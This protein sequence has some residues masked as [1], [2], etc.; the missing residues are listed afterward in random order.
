[1]TKLILLLL[2]T[3]LTASGQN[4]EVNRYVTEARKAVTNKDYPL[5]YEQL[6]KAHAFHPYHQGILY[7]LGV[8]AA[9][10]GKPDESIPYL[11]KA[12]YVNAG[13]KLDIPELSAVKDRADFQQLKT[14]QTELQK[15]VANADTAFVVKDRSLHAESVAVEPK[16]GTCYV[17]SVRKKK[18]VAVDNKGNARSPQ[19]NTD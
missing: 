18:I 2:L 14:L 15:V 19:G 16:T 9:L 1:M 10:T 4:P 17:G 7:Q 8:M 11:R 13:Y 12:L 3:A 6:T 5:A